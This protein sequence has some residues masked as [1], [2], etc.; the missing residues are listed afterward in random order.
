MVLN[1][2]NAKVRTTNAMQDYLEPKQNVPPLLQAA[3]SHGQVSKSCQDPSHLLLGTKVLFTIRY[4]NRH[5]TA[6][7]LFCHYSQVSIK[8]AGYIKRAGWN[9]FEKQLS[10]QAKSSKQGGNFTAFSSSRRQFFLV[11]LL[12]IIVFMINLTIL[13]H[14]IKKIAS[15][16]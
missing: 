10:E 7:I 6:L 9:I 5:I 4:A 1:A 3:I 16:H 14:K 8:R 15:K 2:I 13:G 12:N 11:Q